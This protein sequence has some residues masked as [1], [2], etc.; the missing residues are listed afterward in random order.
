M[1][2]IKYIIS[3]EIIVEWRIFKYTDFCYTKTI[4]E[5]I[6]EITKKGKVYITMIYK[7]F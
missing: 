7:E 1:E 6:D 3:Y 5:I 2:K 4:D